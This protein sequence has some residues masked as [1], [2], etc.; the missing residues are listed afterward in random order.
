M[1]PKL[2]SPE[3]I[4]LTDLDVFNVGRLPARLTLA[5]VGKLLNFQIYE[6]H[7][8][9]LLGMLKCLNS[10]QAGA[11]ARKYFSSGYILSLANDPAWLALAT[12]AV[13]KAVRDKNGTKPL[14]PTRIIESSVPL[15]PVT[16][17]PNPPGVRWKKEM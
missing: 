3:Y 14:R 16:T 17:H 13:A 1:R 2:P 10:P 6:L 8:L 7:L 15:T 12:K 11:N 9:I 5:H 4:D